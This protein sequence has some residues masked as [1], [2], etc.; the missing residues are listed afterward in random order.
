MLRLFNVWY[1][2][3]HCILRAECILVLTKEKIVT[4]SLTVVNQGL[5]HFFR[6]AIKSPIK[7]WDLICGWFTIQSYG[8]LW[9]FSQMKRLRPVNVKCFNWMLKIYCGLSQKWH[10]FMTSFYSLFL[11]W[12]GVVQ[13]YSV[14]LFLFSFMITW[15]DKLYLG[16]C[17][18]ST[19][20]KILSFVEL[21]TLHVRK[22][23]KWSVGVFIVKM[24][25]VVVK[26]LILNLPKYVY[27][28]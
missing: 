12:V 17:L 10:S 7:M 27:V 9:L 23:G 13:L 2:D 20:E 21:W 8:S 14:V 3:L 26:L 15:L 28:Y 1:S 22:E 16:F 4:V 11:F 6:Y 19:Q 18:V 25:C 24:R 5:F